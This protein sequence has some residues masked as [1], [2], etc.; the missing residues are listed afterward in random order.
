MV[1]GRH[2]QDL[3]SSLRFSSKRHVRLMFNQIHRTHLNLI[4]LNLIHLNLTHHSQMEAAAVELMWKLFATLISFHV[5]CRSGR[6]DRMGLRVLDGECLSDQSSQGH[7]VSSPRLRGVRLCEFSD[8]GVT[9][10][11][12]NLPDS[13]CPCNACGAGDTSDLFS[14]ILCFLR[15]HS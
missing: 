10:L 15:C 5:F 11:S 7:L 3:V 4:H 14:R 9:C 1:L 13:G 8:L 2:A 6:R 12:H